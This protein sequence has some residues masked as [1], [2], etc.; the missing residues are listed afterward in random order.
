MKILVKYI[1]G[2]DL[3]YKLVFFLLS[4][5]RSVG[6]KGV[7]ASTQMSRCVMKFCETDKII[8]TCIF[9]DAEILRIQQF[10]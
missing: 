9:N 7:T 6:I 2:V 3:R 1:V 10:Q 8:H 5:M 4:T